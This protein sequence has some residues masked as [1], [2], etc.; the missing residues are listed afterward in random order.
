MYSLCSRRTRASIP[1]P[2]VRADS[3]RCHNR[4]SLACRTRGGSRRKRVS[5]VYVEYITPRPGV[6]IS[7]FHRIARHQQ[8][9]W[10]ARF[11]DDRLLLNLARTWRIGPHPPYLTIWYREAA[12]LEQLDEWQRVFSSG[13]AEDI[14]DAINLVIQIDAAGCYRPLVEPSPAQ[15][16]AYYGEFFEPAAGASEA[17]VRAFFGERAG[18]HHDLRLNLLADRIGHLGPDPRGFAI[19]SAPE[20][21]ALGAIVEELADADGAP[22]DLVRAGLYAPLGEEIL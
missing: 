16:P 14:E 5:L 22:I 1:H 10:A 20:F 11:G 2:G 18:R 6:H 3:S 9:T 7:E 21:G 13:D 15:R 12:G 17:D 19:W 8:E 4:R